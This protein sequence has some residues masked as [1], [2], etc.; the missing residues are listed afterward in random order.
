MKAN[1]I[2]WLIGG[3]GIG[4][5]CTY[6]FATRAGRRLRRNIYRKAEDCTSRVV[7]AGNDML[8]SGRDLVERGK[9]LGNYTTNFLRRGARAFQR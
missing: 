7:A 3:I 5:G 2:P 6:L 4:A 1:G 8:E 9:D